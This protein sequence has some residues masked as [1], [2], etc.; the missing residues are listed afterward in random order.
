M[1]ILDIQDLRFQQRG[2]YAFTVGHGECVG[3]TGPSGSGKTLLLRAIVDLDPH[4]GRVRLDTT[5]CHQ[6]AAPDWRRLVGMLPA[7][8]CWWFDRVAEHFHA[9]DKLDPQQL[10]LLNFTPDVGQWEISR[11]SSGE[12]QRLALLRLLENQPHAL[13]LDEPTA[14][15]DQE[16]SERV[17][18]LLTKYQ[19]QHQAPVL[20]VSH[21][22]EQLARLANRQ[23]FMESGGRLREEA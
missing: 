18:A 20:W 10:A 16:N 12:K 8:S 2:P 6:T 3:L 1:S 4:E 7:E 15:L 19:Q 13:L 9:F 23:F 22:P 17:E 5:W 11:L 21:D 14:S